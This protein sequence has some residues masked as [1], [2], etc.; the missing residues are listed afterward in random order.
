MN[1][2]KFSLKGFLMHTEVSLILIIVLIFLAGTFWTDNF[3]SQYN[4]TNLLKQCSIS[5]VLGIAATF[6][7]ITGG[8]DLSCGSVCGLS[9]L[10]VAICQSWW[11]TS[12]F[13]SILA[14]LV[15]GVLCGL[16]NGIIVNEF[17]VPP[18]I[19]TL[20]S[21]TIIRGVIKVISNGMNVSGLYLNFTDFAAV[22][23]F[24]VLP[25]LA[26]VWILVVF[27]GFL[28]LRY[29][30]FGRNVYLLG[31]GQQV[32]RLCG[33][34]VRKV[35]YMVY[36]LAG[37][38]CGIGG[39]MLAARISCAQPTG[40]EGYEMTAI[41]ATVLGGA[42]LAGGKGFVD[43]GTLSEALRRTGVREVERIPEE[44]EIDASG[45][46]FAHGVSVSRVQT[47]FTCPLM[48]FLEAGL[49]L[50]P[51]PDGVLAANDI[52]TFMHGVMEAFLKE[53]GVD[54]ETKV[55]QIVAR[56]LAE[57][58]WLL[59]GV[60]SVEIEA[61][62]KEAVKLAEAV[63]ERM[64]KFVPTYF[65]EK[66]GGKDAK[67]KGIEIAV[68]GKS[69][70]VRGTIDRLDLY[71]NAARVVD[72]KT[73]K[74][75]FKMGDLYYG[76]RVQL[77]VYMKAA[78]ANGYTRAGTFYFPLS[79][80]FDIDENK[81]Y[82]LSGVFDSDYASAMDEGLATASYIS[83]AVNAKTTAKA[84]LDGRVKTYSADDLCA[85]SDYGLAVLTAGAKEMTDGYIAASPLVAN[86][87][88]PP[89]GW[90]KM[91]AVCR[92][93]ACTL[94]KRKQGS[95]GLERI[96]AGLQAEREKEEKGNA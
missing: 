71:G 95:A 73:G 87:K 1:E 50:Q 38:F 54:A 24:G 20:G 19:A 43:E 96:A 31:S 57:D 33:V 13:V 37:F 6:I 39:I 11:H 62:T 82:R 77:A 68:G 12:I 34:S 67:L 63:S 28:I 15:V 51:R 53:G 3:F 16:Y 85:V 25:A 18:F 32:A 66:F 47:Y 93:R 90:C 72:Y 75:E 7:I 89:C 84:K 44:D 26:L 60:T 80:P 14:G 78:E 42:S 29:T 36:S 21:M 45:L 48:G 70:T 94:K 41:T 27:A 59:K 10:M 91:V 88:N 81:T 2:K 83:P 69:Y 46:Y 56:L 65:E 86:E 9:C 23:L 17:H 4:L 74:A 8:I 35:T 55:P 64:G 76:T 22:R 49:K 52:G 30:T 79:T 5:G 40:G 92:A 61:F 58:E